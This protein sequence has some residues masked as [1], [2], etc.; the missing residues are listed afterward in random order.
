MLLW[1]RV[2][3]EWFGAKRARRLF[4][5]AAAL[6]VTGTA[7]LCFP[8]PAEPRFAVK[9]VLGLA[10]VL[11]GLSVFFL[12]SGMWQYWIRRDPSSRLARRAWFVILL[13]GFWYGAV[14]YCLCVYLRNPEQGP[15]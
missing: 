10:G 6:V 14:A 9:L 7:V 15:E 13:V 8:I 12:W 3:D 11:A 4:S 1:E 2:G 5:A